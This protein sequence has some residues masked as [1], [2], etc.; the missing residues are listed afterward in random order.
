[1]KENTKLKERVGQLEKEV[2]LLRNTNDKVQKQLL[3]ANNQLKDTQ[4]QLTSTRLQLKDTQKK[5]ADALKRK[6]FVFCYT[7]QFLCH[8]LHSL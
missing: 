1:M 2:E 8:L 5:L 6:L 7:P 4:Q 3:S